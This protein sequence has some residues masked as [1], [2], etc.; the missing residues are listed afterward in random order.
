[1]DVLENSHDVPKLHC[2]IVSSGCVCRH[3]FLDG[4]DV[5]R[6]GEAEFAISGQGLLGLLMIV[7]DGASEAVKGLFGIGR[8]GAERLECRAMAL[9][10]MNTDIMELQLYAGRGRKV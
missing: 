7:C 4:A 1:M 10:N 6:N 5:S 8:Q 2:L 3:A 9:R